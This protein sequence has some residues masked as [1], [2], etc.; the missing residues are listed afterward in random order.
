MPQL[1]PYFGILGVILQTVIFLFGGYA[2]VIRNEKSTEL[3]QKQVAEMQREIRGMAEVVTQLAVQTTRLDGLNERFN[4]LDQRFE[5]MR[6]GQ[7]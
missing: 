3:L 6:R 2:I 7:H 1:V 5:D 4:L